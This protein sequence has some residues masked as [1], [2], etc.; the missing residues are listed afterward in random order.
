M[1]QLTCCAALVIPRIGNA[2]VEMSHVL[3]VTVVDFYELS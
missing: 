3:Y 1:H 2:T